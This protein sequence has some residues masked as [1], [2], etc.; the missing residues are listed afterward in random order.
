MEKECICK[1][2][3]FFNARRTVIFNFHQLKRE[4][5]MKTITKN[6]TTVIS[7]WS[8]FFGAMLMV[9]LMVSAVAYS[10]ASGTGFRNSR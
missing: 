6:P 1:T 8:R 2:I 9:A 7:R 10:H 5:F 3:E 4:V